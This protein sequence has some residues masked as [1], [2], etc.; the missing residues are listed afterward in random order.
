MTRR[1]DC[2]PGSVGRAGKPVAVVCRVPAS[3]MHTSGLVPLWWRTDLVV[4]PERLMHDPGPIDAVMA[5]SELKLS[6]RI[7]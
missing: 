7:G 1:R 2:L 3:Y 4:D 6:P 5:A